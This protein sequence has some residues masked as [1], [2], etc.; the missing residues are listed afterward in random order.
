MLCIFAGPEPRFR[1]GLVGAGLTCSVFV[2]YGEFMPRETVQK[3]TQPIRVLAS[4][5][6][7]SIRIHFFNWNERI[8]KVE[9]ANLFHIERD[10]ATKRYHFAVTSAGNDYQIAFNPITLDWQLEEVVSV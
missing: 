6:E 1:L 9:S 5:A 8:Y 4:F 3:I 7:N 10:G 2:R